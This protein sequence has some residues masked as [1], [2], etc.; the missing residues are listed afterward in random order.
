MEENQM[1]A[2]LIKGTFAYIV[3]AIIFI[4]GIGHL[5][6]VHAADKFPREPG[7]SS[8]KPNPP[9]DHLRCE[10]FGHQSSRGCCSHDIGACLVLAYLVHTSC[11]TG[12]E[13]APLLRPPTVPALTIALDRAWA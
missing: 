9:L 10:G 2:T 1:K 7:R 12:E 11:R 8:N 13:A 6:H 5:D 3:L 4:I